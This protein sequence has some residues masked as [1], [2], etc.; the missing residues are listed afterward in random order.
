MNKT[1]NGRV[2]RLGA[3][4]MG[5]ATLA[6]AALTMGA[7]PA[8]ASGPSTPYLEPALTAPHHAPAPRLSWDGTYAG[9]SLGYACCGRDRVQLAPAPPG[10]FGTM[11]ESGA[12]AGLHLG[13]NW[14]RGNTVVGVE[15]DVSF[16]RIGD[17]LED[18]TSSA[19]VR[20][21]PA[22]SLRARFGHTVGNGLVYATGGVAAARIAYSAGDTAVGSDIQSTYN[23]PGVTAGLGYEHM[24]AGGA[25]SARAEY[26]YTLYRGRDLTDGVQT[27]RA[28]PDYHAI[29]FGLSRRF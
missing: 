8:L 12:F 23:V 7:V 14:Q 19:S 24:L 3:L 1:F 17:E 21:N 4:R 9:L 20:I 26:S 27:T 22:M 29:R 18:G 28:T 10:V 15:A 13:H 25:W 11:E 2:A 6:L 5:T 16:G